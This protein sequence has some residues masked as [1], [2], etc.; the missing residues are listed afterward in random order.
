MLIEAGSIELTIVS[1]RS[2]RFSVVA[3]TTLQGGSFGGH[4]R[5]EHGQ[6]R[7]F[8]KLRDGK[9]GFPV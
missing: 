8:P 6:G 1:G 2:S 4:Y 7:P 3:I 5:M 9:L